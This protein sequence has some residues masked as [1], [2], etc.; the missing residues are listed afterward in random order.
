MRKLFE[1]VLLTN[2]RCSISIDPLNAIKL[3][4]SVRMKTGRYATVKSAT[5]LKKGEKNH[6]LTG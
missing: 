5:N 2:S 4:V 3:H 1:I 6:E